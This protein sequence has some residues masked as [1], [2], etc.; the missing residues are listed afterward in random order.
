[1]TETTTSSA[2]ITQIC[3]WNSLFPYS[4]SPAADVCIATDRVAMWCTRS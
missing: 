2:P 4:V 1:M 3:T